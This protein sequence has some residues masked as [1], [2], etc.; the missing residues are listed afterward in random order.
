MMLWLVGVLAL[1]TSCATLHAWRYRP[2]A[3]CAD[4]LPP[5]IFQ[6]ERCPPNGICGYTC[7]PDRWLCRDC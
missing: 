5:V 7:E 3:R 6:H 1:S 2:P 4:G